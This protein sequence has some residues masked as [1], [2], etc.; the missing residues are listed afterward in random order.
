[1]FNGYRDQIHL[2]DSQNIAIFNSQHML[3]ATSIQTER[4]RNGVLFTT[5]LWYEG[6]G[7]V[8]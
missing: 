7:L 4:T 1:M 5:E 8:W 3:W 2:T 6:V